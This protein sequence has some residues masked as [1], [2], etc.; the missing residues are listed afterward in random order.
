MKKTFFMNIIA[1]MLVAFCSFSSVY[2]ESM[3]LPLDVMSTKIED[4]GHYKSLNSKNATISYTYDDD[5]IDFKYVVKNGENEKVYTTSFEL[6][7]DVYSYTY[8]GD[9]TDTTQIKLNKIAFESVLYA[10]GELNALQK[11][12]LEDM[13]KDYSRYNFDEYGIEVKTFTYGN[14]KEAIE[15]FKLHTTEISAY[16][17]SFMPIPE[18]ETEVVTPEPEPEPKNNTFKFVVLGLILVIV[19]SLIVVLTVKTRKIK[20]AKEAKKV[21]KKSSKK[22]K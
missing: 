6:K 5:S 14:G 19:V 22:T 20:K 8:T 11:D 17:T 9:K 4:Q 1:I 16:G 18:P 2:A 10:V 3:K 21:T 15:S 12:F 13:S 7:D